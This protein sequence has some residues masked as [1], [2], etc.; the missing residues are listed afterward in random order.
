M[1]GLVEGLGFCKFYVWWGGFGMDW[2]EGMCG[3]DSPHA[4]ITRSGTCTEYDGEF[5]DFSTGD[6]SYQLS[7]VFRNPAFLRVC[8]DH[9]TADVLQK[10]KGNVALRTE[11]DEVCAFESGF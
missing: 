10:D 8:S 1:G 6:G 3:M 2:W 4:I 5:R 7:A 9:E 11:L